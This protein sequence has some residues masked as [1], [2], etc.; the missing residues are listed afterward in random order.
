MIPAIAELFPNAEHRYCLRHIHENMKKNW[1]G[2]EYKEYVWKCATATTVPEFQAMMREF[3]EYDKAAHDWLN[4]IPPKH[5]ARSH[6]TGYI[7]QLHFRVT[8]SQLHF[9]IILFVVMN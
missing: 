8:I 9:N 1:R 4:Q 5:W 6:F 2:R 7:L 3:G